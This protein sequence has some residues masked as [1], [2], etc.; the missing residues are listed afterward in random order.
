MAPGSQTITSQLSQAGKHQHYK[1]SATQKPKRGEPS[2]DWS[3]DSAAETEYA[4]QGF[5]RHPSNPCY[6]GN[7]K[8]NDDPDISLH[9]RDDSFDE[10][11]DLAF[12]PKQISLLK[13]TMMDFLKEFQGLRDQGTDLNQTLADFSNKLPMEKYIAAKQVHPENDPDPQNNPETSLLI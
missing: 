4:L 9:A 8:D 3:A 13:S 7:N 10:D 5:E 6:I 2:S 1:V 12:A 11:S